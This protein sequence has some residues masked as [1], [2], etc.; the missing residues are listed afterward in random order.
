MKKTKLL[1]I[2]ALLCLTGIMGCSKLINSLN[3][4]LSEDEESEETSHGGNQSQGGQDGDN[5]LSSI[6]KL[7]NDRNYYLDFTGI[8]ELAFTYH[9]HVDGYHVYLPDTEDYYDYTGADAN[10]EYQYYEY[11]EDEQKYYHGYESLALEPGYSRLITRARLSA[12]DFVKTNVVDEYEMV[13]NR[14]EEYGLSHFE[15]VYSSRQQTITF[16][17]QCDP[18][19]DRYGNFSFSGKFY[20]FGQAHVTLPS[21]FVNE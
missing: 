21:Y 19:S 3:S 18:S 7:I 20:N 11:D 17:G 6:L 12:S 15:I 14:L 16:A 10:G 8:G 9:Y 1:I 4:L 13:E 2:H 5:A